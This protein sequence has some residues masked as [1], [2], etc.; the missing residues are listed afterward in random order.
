MVYTCAYQEPTFG[1]LARLCALLLMVHT[2]DS[3]KDAILLATRAAWTCPVEPEVPGV[4]FP[5]GAA[6]S[7][8]L[9]GAGI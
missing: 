9:T 6:L 5:Q 7:Q 2:C 3:F 8:W 4:T 1:S